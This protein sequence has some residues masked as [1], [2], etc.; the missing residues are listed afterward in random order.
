MRT[1]TPEVSHTDY[2]FLLGMLVASSFIPQRTLFFNTPTTSHRFS[3]YNEYHSC[4]IISA[5]QALSR[6]LHTS[7]KPNQ[8]RLGNMYPAFHCQEYKRVTSYGAVVQLAVESSK[9][10]M[11]RHD[12]ALAGTAGYLDE[13]GRSSCV[14]TES[15]HFRLRTLG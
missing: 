5:A 3:F 13:F 9:A 7:R 10:V 15:E 2:I 4:P 11:K 6:S 12:P 1:R 8:Y 14:T